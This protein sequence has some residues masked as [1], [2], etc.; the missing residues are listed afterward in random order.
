M[1]C[2]FS[3]NLDKFKLETQLKNLIHNV[4]YKQVAI[5][6]ILSLNASPKLVVYEVLVKLI[7]TAPATNTVSESSCSMLCRAKSYL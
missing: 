7:L 2:F 4:D 6:I 1:S 3:S 5:K